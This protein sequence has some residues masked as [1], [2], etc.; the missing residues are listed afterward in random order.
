MIKIIADSTAYVTKE[1]AQENDI[2]II[3][4]RYLLRDK[5]Y[6]E[7]FPG[8]FDEFFKDF[9]TN[10]VF[11]KTSQPSLELFI[12]EY[13]K[14]IAN[15]D[16]VLVFTIGSTFSGTFNA[17]LLAKEQCSDPSKVTVFDSQGLAQTIYGYIMEA[18][19]MRNDGKTVS[20]IVTYLDGCID[21]SSIIFVPDT[22]E[23]IQKGGRIGKVTATIGSLLQ[24]K[25]IVVCNKNVL[26]N[27]KSFGLQKAI[28]DMFAMIPEKINR[29]FILHLA[30]SEMF[31]SFKQ[32]AYKMLGTRKDYG[33]F[34]IYEGEV[35]P[36]VGTHAG[37]AVGF[38]WTAPAQA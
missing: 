8:T 17:A 11:P 5:E 29:L 10:K 37:P 22:L 3:P 31:E 34:E 2:T 27:K 9:T 1:Y 15:G 4:L 38:A 26:S 33:Q 35:G 16:E 32:T 25:P 6:V 20:E 13:N 7:G 36:V 24:I 28:K 18:V 23:Y 12:D 21:K 30:K 19:N 14:A